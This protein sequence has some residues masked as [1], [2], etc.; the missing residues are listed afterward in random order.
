MI[1]IISAVITSFGYLCHTH[2]ILVEKTEF[3]FAFLFQSNVFFYLNLWEKHSYNYQK[4]IS[5][6]R[7]EFCHRSIFQD[8]ASFNSQFAGSDVFRFFYEPV[9]NRFHPDRHRCYNSSDIFPIPMDGWNELIQ[10]WFLIKW[11]RTGSLWTDSELV[12]YE[13]SQNWFFIPICIYN[14]KNLSSYFGKSS[15]SNDES[16][17]LRP[18]KEII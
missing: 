8:I 7:N 4:Q 5:N 11:F 13:L 2:H 12:L 17:S 6:G 18:M 9:L 3:F 15:W 10:N 14:T 16:W 1:G